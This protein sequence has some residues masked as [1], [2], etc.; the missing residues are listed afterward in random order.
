MPTNPLGLAAL[1]PALKT[2]PPPTQPLPTYQP[3]TGTGGLTPIDT[4]QPPQPTYQ[5]PM[6][7][8][9]GGTSPVPQQP[10]MMDTAG[11]LPTQ[12]GVM[13]ADG[14]MYAGRESAPRAE[15]GGA[16][17]P[18]AGQ[19]GEYGQTTGDGFWGTRDGQNYVNGNLFAA[20]GL[21]S[22]NTD[23]S[24]WMSHHKPMWDAQQAGTFTPPPSSGDG[25]DPSATGFGG[26]PNAT[27]AGGSSGLTRDPGAIPFGGGTAGP[28]AGN[29]DGT[30]TTPGGTTIP[31]P[32]G[33]GGTSPVPGAPGA[34][35]P[36]VSPH[37]TDWS[38][39]AGLQTD[40]EGASRNASDAAYRRATQFFDEDFGRDRAGL[41]SQ[42]ANQGFARG[43][44]A[45]NTELN[46]M[47]RQQNAARS[48]AALSAQQIGHQQANDLFGRSL[49]ARGMLG[50]ERERS[51]DRRF[52]QEMGIANLGLGA[53]GQDLNRYGIDS[54]R[55]T[56][57]DTAGLGADLR[58][59][60]LGLAEDG[61]GFNQLM[62]L[63]SGARGG[64]N[65][66]NFG[67]PNPLDV[68]GAYGIA[69]QANNSQLN[70]DAQDRT[71]LY[72]LGG[73]ALSGID[74]GRL[75]SGA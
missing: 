33:T 63:L 64:V 14:T 15:T 34:W 23:F 56:T 31:P 37:A 68:G 71:N 24:N 66:P 27:T 70:R 29:T 12:G 61:Q 67:N 52:S 36:N 45:F 57:M 49:A 47:E 72:N 6:M 60:E 16:F 58:L 30:R 17:N 22:G 10:R 39:I 1:D 20:S 19:W 44:E 8:Q 42:L 74:W 18:A 65:V 38:G 69:N 3:P 53:R 46:R 75:F 32:T 13:G 25:S 7:E 62:A 40:F 43:S 21:D 9:T 59:R 41:E 55:Q 48:N 11:M 4:F 50:G 35:N 73:A 5:P 51:A 28:I 26:M 2:S 54:S